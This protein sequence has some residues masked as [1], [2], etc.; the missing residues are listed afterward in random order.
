M[1]AWNSISKRGSRG[2]SVPRAI[3]NEINQRN[4]N[5]KGD[6]R[7]NS[8]PPESSAM[9]AVGASTSVSS[10]APKGCYC[11]MGSI[12]RAIISLIFILA[13]SAGVFYWI[14]M[15]QFHEEVVLVV[16]P[17]I[18]VGGEVASS[19]SL[20]NVESGLSNKKSNLS[21]DVLHELLNNRSDLFETVRRSKA[22]L[23]MEINFSQ[24][25]VDKEEVAEAAEDT[26]DKTEAENDDRK[27][28]EEPLE[29]T[30]LKDKNVRL[31][32]DFEGKL[33]RIKDLEKH[34]NVTV[35]TASPETTTTTTTTAAATTPQTTPK[36]V[37]EPAVSPNVTEAVTTSEAATTSEP[38][39]VTT[40]PIEESTTKASE[41]KLEEHVGFMPTPFK[42]PNINEPV[43]KNSDNNK[44]ASKGR[45][46]VKKCFVM[47]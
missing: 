45:R 40:V 20:E 17:I 46:M 13:L 21:S 10:Q 30:A 18:E 43:L 8:P 15:T 12:F 32:I 4:N 9:S 24:E 2:S 3:A 39:R 1:Y 34:E 26:F 31:Y 36:P 44:N 29:V 28:D 41:Q 11:Q 33:H 38:P 19:N 42:Q 23:D 25:D 22:I 27:D 47:F 5:H 6:N 7:V 16:E 37:S 14:Y 35:I